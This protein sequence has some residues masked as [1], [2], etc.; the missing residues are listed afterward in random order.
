MFPEIKYNN[1][2]GA[3]QGFTLLEVLVALAILTIALASTIK[4]TTNQSLNAEHLRDKTLAHWVAMNQIAEPQLT[5][6]WLPVG[7]KQGTEEMG[8]REWHWQ[9][10]VSDTPDARVRRIQLKVFRDR[11]DESPITQ[12]TSFLTQPK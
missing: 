1:R 9:R 5:Q 2:R 8:L 7:K 12:L 10:I 4:V 6:E 3:H 11:D